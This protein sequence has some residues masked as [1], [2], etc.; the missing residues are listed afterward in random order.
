MDYL[1]GHVSQIGTRT[2]GPIQVGSELNGSIVTAM[3]LVRGNDKTWAL[4][5]FGDNHIIMIL[6]PFSE[7]QTVLFDAPVPAETDATS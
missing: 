5:V 7:T 6:H 3:R 1:I 4:Q 2:Y